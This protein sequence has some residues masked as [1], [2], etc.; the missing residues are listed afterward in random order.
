MIQTQRLLLIL[1]F[2]GASIFALTNSAAAPA[3]KTPEAKPAAKGLPYGIAS[4]KKR[5]KRLPGQRLVHPKPAPKDKIGFIL[6]TVSNKTLK[7]T[8]HL[9][10]LAK[11]ESR[12]IKLEAK[13]DGKWK[14]VAT[15]TVR[16]N[17]Y[18]N[19]AKARAWNALFRVEKWDTTKDIP[20]RVVA[21]DGV[22]TYE[23]LI[24]KDPIG[25]EEIVVAAFT[26]NSNQE[27]GLKPDIIKNVLAHK[28]DLLFFSGDQSYDHRNHYRAWMLFGRQFGEL[29]RQCPTVCL[30]DDHDV[31]MGNIWGSNGK[32][33]KTGAGDDGGFYMPVPYVNEVYFAQ[34]AHMPDPYD[35]TPI[36]RDISVCYGSFKVGGVDFAIIEDRKFKTG[37]KEVITKEI[38]TWPGRVDFITD[39]TVDI[40]TVDFPNAKLLGD[41][42][43]KFL[44]A[45]SKNW[46]GAEMKCVLSQTVLAN[47][48]HAFFH[49]DRFV[50]ADMD[51][52]GW[53]QTGRNK[54]LAEIR[55]GYAFMI[56]GDQHLATVLHHGIDEFNDAGWSFCVPSIVNY[57]KRWWNP[58]SKP[59]LPS[60]RKSPLKNLGSY[61]DGFLNRVTMQAYANPGAAATI[62]KSKHAETASGH[63]IV[64]FNKAKRTITME[65]WPRGSDVT[66]PDAKQY[67]GW[68]VTVTQA[69]NYGRKA[70]AWLPKLTIAGKADPVV[71]IIDEATKKTVYTIR[72]K[73]NT[74]QPK[75][76]KAGTYT[77]LVGEGK[78]LRSHACAV[79][80]LIPAAAAAASRLFPSMRFCLNNRTCSSVT[81]HATP[82]PKGEAAGATATNRQF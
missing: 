3:A 57:Y 82:S 60:G 52:N 80:T 67:P 75:V 73:G 59:L 72:I 2:A 58:R 68:P 53:P 34:T 17:E 7:L 23:G 25:K 16:E 49:D 65:C 46:T 77:I 36:L 19:R 69:D 37:P 29:T 61:Y 33:S 21:L 5:S 6:Y 79:R 18:K 63:G 41:R 12:E 70:K 74:V 45:W 71:Q 66:Q 43:L 48:A 1:A 24:R 56:C 64:R 27:R 32:K 31:G 42:Q 47:A 10:E 22:A 11:E 30:P 28:V 78:S 51:S 4:S 44:N 38:K 26:G 14:P 9:Y 13:I 35:P 76:F 55:R 39:P 54:A 40:K 15:S 62:T 8:A 50:V 81:I 20:V